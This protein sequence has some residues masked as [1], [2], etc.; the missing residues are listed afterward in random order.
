MLK[1]SKFI[2]NGGQ[3]QQQLGSPC[4]SLMYE[5]VNKI[6]LYLHSFLSERAGHVDFGGNYF[7]SWYF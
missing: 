1:S 6:L 5:S 4:V 7:N 3:V 2:G